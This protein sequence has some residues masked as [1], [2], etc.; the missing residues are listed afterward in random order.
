MTPKDKAKELVDKIY[1]DI[2]FDLVGMPTT[3]KMVAKQC[4]LIS[5]DEILN[6]RPVITDSQFEYN[7]YWQEVKKEINKI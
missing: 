2:D 5:V 3:K 4:A 7:K 6:S 1:Y